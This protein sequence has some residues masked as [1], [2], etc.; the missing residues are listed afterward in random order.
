MLPWTYPGYSAVTPKKK[1][2]NWQ[3][4]GRNSISFIQERLCL[5]AK[6]EAVC[7]WKSICQIMI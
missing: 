1:K 3:D 5:F 6:L 2:K 4:V 7:L